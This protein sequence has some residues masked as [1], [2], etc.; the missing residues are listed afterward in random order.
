MYTCDY[1][2]LCKYM[3]ICVYV[4]VCVCVFNIADHINWLLVLELSSNLLSFY[5][6]T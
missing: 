6:E 2:Y 5:L 4:H 1:G 3:Y